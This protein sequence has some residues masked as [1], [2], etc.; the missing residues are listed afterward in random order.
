VSTRNDS[1]SSL[2]STDSSAGAFAQFQNGGPDR[3]RTGYL[4][5]A[6]A[7]RHNSPTCEDARKRPLTC[8]FPFPVVLSVSGCFLVS[9]AA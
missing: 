3:D 7:V 6:M 4:R 5:H 1:A 2:P 8:G 9:R